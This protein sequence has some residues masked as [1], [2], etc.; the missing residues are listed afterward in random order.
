ML[1]ALSLRCRCCSCCRFC[2][3]VSMSNAT[4][5][6]GCDRPLPGLTMLVFLPKI[7]N[8][9]RRLHRWCS[10]DRTAAM[11]YLCKKTIF[12][13]RTYKFF[14]TLSCTVKKNASTQKSW[15]V[16]LLRKRGS[17]TSSLS[18]KPYFSRFA[19]WHFFSTA[20]SVLNFLAYHIYQTQADKKRILICPPPKENYIRMNI[21]IPSVLKIRYQYFK[22][23]D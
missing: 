8:R 14:M 10:P 22:S 23:K 19:R 4:L 9:R 17:L 13:D 21:S 12:D 2:G 5:D 16:G 7:A 11:L 3:L 20:I 15:K 6:S 1:A 18:C